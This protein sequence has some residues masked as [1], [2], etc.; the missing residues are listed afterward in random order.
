MNTCPYY[1]ASTG[2]IKNGRKPSGT[3]RYLC[4][5]CGRAYTPEPKLSGYDETTGR[6]AVQMYVDGLNL[7]RIAR[8]LQVNH[9]RVANWVNAYAAQLPAPPI[10]DQVETV[11]LDELFTFVAAKKSQTYSAE[12][13]NAELRHYL[14]RSSRC[15]SRSLAALH[16]AVRLFVFVWNHRQL[17][18]H[19]LPNYPASLAEF[20]PVLV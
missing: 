11:E 19:T 20:L 13:V 2:Q 12:A 18:K 16:Q 17:Y 7:R 8:L 6:R 14:A 3:Q 5:Q 4:R 10:L 15:F 9:Q 1:Q